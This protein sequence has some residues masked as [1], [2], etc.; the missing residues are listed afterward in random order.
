M[1]LAQNIARSEGND[2]LAIRLEKLQHAE[3]IKKMV[4]YAFM[5]DREYNMVA[6][7]RVT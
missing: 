2:E 4:K 6:T 1:S 7:M 5:R 3:A